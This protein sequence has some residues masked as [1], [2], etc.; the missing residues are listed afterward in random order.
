[1]N[2]Q[3]IKRVILNHRS[4]SAGFI[5]VSVYDSIFFLFCL[6]KL[7]FENLENTNLP[8]AITYDSKQ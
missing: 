1:M 8:F 3:L 7:G 6:I 5:Q 4:K 2:Y